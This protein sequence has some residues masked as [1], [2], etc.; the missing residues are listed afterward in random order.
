MAAKTILT[1]LTLLLVLSGMA[2]NGID[3]PDVVNYSKFDYNAGAQTWDIRQDKSG[4]LYF[5]NN[6]GLLAFDGT[7]WKTYPLPNKTIARSIEIGPDNKIYIGAQDEMGYFSP[8]QQGRLGYHS[9]KPLLPE[10]EKSFADI[11]DV[12]PFDGDIF[13]RSSNR[14]YQ[15]GNQRIKTYLTPAWQFIAVCNGQLIAQDNNFRLL[16]FQRGSWVPV[17]DTRLMPAEYMIT[18]GLAISS[19]STL[20]VTLKNGLFLLTANTVSPIISPGLEEVADQHIYSA[21]VASD[22]TFALGT[23]LGGVYFV[24]K[25]G[26]LLRHISREQGL[27][28]NNVLCL[29]SD[30]QRN[31]WLGL[32]NGIDLM[33]YDQAIRH[34]YAG[35]QNESSGYTSILFDNQLYLGTSNG[36]Y[37]APIDT[38]NNSI[39][40]SAAFTAVPNA[41]GQ[42]WNLAE[43]N[44]RLLMGHHEG[45]FQVNKNRVELLDRQSGFW[46][47]LPLQNIL[48]AST[49]VAGNYMGLRFFHFDG[50]KFTLLTQQANFESARFVSVD[51]ENTIW[52]A[53]PYKGLYRISLL[54]NSAPGVKL[55]GATE[56]LQ[57]VNF[58]FPYRNKLLI[59][60]E[61]GIY[62]YLPDTETFQPNVFLT[63][64]FA[65]NSIRYLRE[66]AAGNIWFVH[67]KTLGVID[68]S[69]G[70]GKITYIPELNNKLV[71]GFE[72]IN[73]LTRQDVLVGGEKGFYLVNLEAYKKKKSLLPISLR[74]V[75]IGKSSD[76]LIFGGYFGDVGNAQ[77]QPLD[78]IFEIDHG[79]N[80]IHFEYAAPSFGNNLNLEYSY[81]LKGFDQNWSEW[82]R[83]T[84]KDYTN[85]PA[86]QYTFQY[87][88]R[89]NLGLES[90]AGTYTFSIKPPWYASREAYFLYVLIFSVAVYALYQWQEKRF[91][92]Q[93]QKHDEE[94]NRLQYLH[95]LEMEKTEKEI[96]KLRNEKLEAEI[97]HKNTELASTALHLVQKSELIAKVKEDLSRQLRTVESTS[98]LDDLKRMVKV[99]GEDEKMDKEWETFAHHFDKVHSDFLVK[100]KAQH[101]ILT[102]NELKLC[103]YLR[104]NLT[105][106]EIA[107]LLKIS[108]RGVEI[109]RYRLRKKLQLPTET[110]LFDYLI[111]V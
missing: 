75:A 25:S 103:A 105:T 57:G 95:Q 26:R 77:L 104:M 66:D 43:V 36:L 70:Q 89:T 11:W 2:Q 71:S 27:Q 34:F 93:Q 19:D 3:I 100:L 91:L 56:G 8:D 7:S 31:L 47:F 78:R 94:Q 62:E 97:E 12:I 32:D 74:K 53:H 40:M 67:E 59:A 39:R 68:M 73:P 58:I 20:L 69:D 29:F 102:A 33:V 63:R 90:D 79:C 60:T 82:S 107:P 38:G 108:V 4:I 13:F 76:S 6:E 81:L 24:D 5:A 109:S 52:V 64:F 23:T 85:L 111:A 16:T 55:F 44:G 61:K 99:L 50:E 72:H 80:S 98:P 106:K 87:K 49:M 45:A 65:S 37:V 9:L 28:N 35:S 96:V 10:S 110:N 14:I 1:A 18:A 48:P 22:G 46:T 88:A 83:K 54:G 101:P 17:I 30:R 51:G 21:A 41:K 86:G 84:E 42:V 15:Y 92:K